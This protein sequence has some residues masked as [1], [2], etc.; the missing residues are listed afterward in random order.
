MALIA[1]VTAIIFSSCN[2]D[3]DIVADTGAN[4]GGNIAGT[5]FTVVE[6]LPA[7][8]Q[9]INEKVS[10]FDNVTTMEAACEYAAGR[11]GSNLFVSL[12]SWGGYIVVKAGAAI[13]NTGGYDFSIAG[14][15]FDSSNEAGIVWVMQDTNGNGL[16][17]DTWYELR[18]S[19]YGMEGYERDYSVTYFR[20]DGAGDVRWKDSRGEEG[21]VKWM[22]QFH[23]QN[24]Y[25]G[26]VTADSYTLKGTRLPSLVYQDEAGVW[27][28]PPFG[29]G[30]AD[31][32]GE[33]S[34]IIPIGGKTIQKNFFR[35]SD[36]IDASGGSVDLDG[37]DFIKVQTAV[38]GTSGVIGE[39][40]TE[41]CGFF[42]P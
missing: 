22:G 31:N 2:K 32:S 7:P 18:G 39:N 25:P 4:T 3:D 35:I 28:N 27:I 41:V 21:V 12:G 1:A 6:Y 33:D 19:Y 16:P 37:I 11:L 29:W 26:W 13:P 10:G 40:S 38:N 34:E 42:R 30:Y 24:Y 5:D 14:N 15:S 8:G 23:A 9:F 17:D 36:A 20:P